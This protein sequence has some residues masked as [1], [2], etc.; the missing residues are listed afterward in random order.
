MLQIRNETPFQADRALL[1]D[2]AG[3]QVWVVAIKATYLIDERGGAQP[4]PSQEPVVASPVW[5][6]AP[7][8][9]SLLRE[10][11]LVVA[12]PG[13]DVTFNATAHAPR[14][15]PAATV[16][17]G[18]MVGPAKKSLRVYGDRVWFKGATGL[19][20][21]APRPFERMPV[22]WERAYGGSEGDPEDDR[23]ACETRNPVGLGFAT[24]SSRLADKPLP[25][26]E[27]P[28]HLIES[29]RDRPPPAGLGAVAPDWSPRRERG[30]TY[31]EAWRRSRAPLWPS[32]HDP[33]FHL[34]APLGL[35][36]EAPLKGG[37]VVSTIGLTP[38]G[39]LTFAL[40][41][42]YLVVETRLGGAWS[43]QR[44]KLERVIG[45]PDER[46]LILVWSARLV[47]GARG[48]EV[49]LTRIVTKEWVDA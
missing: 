34:S 43:R 9:S 8:R 23:F 3:N 37:E 19:A 21:S 20:R 31:D 26:I 25:N 4:C 30:G 18:V 46:K 12:H 44:V 16:E 41:R 10:S 45:E 35:S 39:P 38:E 29:W 28:H 36:L 11:E 27:D 17:V 2:A 5:S 13:T 32:D 47:C 22:V 7:G 6:G 1:L 40:P 14:G 42:E 49:E 15:H 33:R 24:S 48:R